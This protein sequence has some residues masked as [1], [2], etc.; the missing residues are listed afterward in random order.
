[1]LLKDIKRIS[2]HWM[3]S[4]GRELIQQAIRILV[5]ITISYLKRKLFLELARLLWRAFD[6]D[7]LMTV[8]KNDRKCGRYGKD[9]NLKSTLLVVV[10]IARRR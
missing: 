5:H 2:N 7:H 1:M 3:G 10:P 8:R 4:L 6:R 9:T